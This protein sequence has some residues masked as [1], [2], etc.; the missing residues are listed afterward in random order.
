M[1]L[2]ATLCNFACHRCMPAA[3]GRCTCAPRRSKTIRAPRGRGGCP[4]PPAHRTPGAGEPTGTPP[5]SRSPA[6]EG[7]GH[8]FGPRRPRDGACVTA[9][10]YAPLD[11]RRLT[12]ASRRTAPVSKSDAGADAAQRGC[13]PQ[14][15]CAALTAQRADS[16]KR[17]RRPRGTPP[18]VPS[19]GAALPRRPSFT[20]LRFKKRAAAKPR[21]S[22]DGFAGCAAAPPAG[23]ARVRAQVEIRCAN[24]ALDAAALRLT[25]GAAPDTC[26]SRTS[27]SSC[28]RRPSQAWHRRES[29]AC[30]SGSADCACGYSPTPC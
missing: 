7:T 15:K 20:S 14:R 10:P 21:R 19:D 11:G 17:G 5:S 3:A 25:S 4:E 30:P 1:Q 8:R 24:F 2:A 26:S 29:R 13:K 27:C 18:R 6:A 9:L 16:R 22:S 12:P 23:L 28:D